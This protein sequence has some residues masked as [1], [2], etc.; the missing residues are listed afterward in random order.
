MGNLGKHVHVPGLGPEI[1]IS[2]SGVNKGSAIITLMKD[3]EAHLGVAA[4]DVQD[5]RGTDL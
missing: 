3:A 5:N 2:P 4:C 1:D